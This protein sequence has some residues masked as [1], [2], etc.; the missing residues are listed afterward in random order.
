MSGYL[1]QCIVSGACPPS[2]TSGSL[3]LM[4]TVFTLP[5]VTSSPV[6]KKICAGDNTSFSASGAGTG[7]TYQW[8]VDTGT[9]YKNVV[10][11]STYTGAAT[12]TLSVLRAGKN[13]RGHR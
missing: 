9:G 2:V 1:Y 7:I 8:Q 6:D 13:M 5:S 10:N 11:S 4:L 12:G 3:T